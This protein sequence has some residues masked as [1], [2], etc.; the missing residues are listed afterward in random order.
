MMWLN[1]NPK[2]DYVVCYIV[3]M[4]MRHNCVLILSLQ[5]R[6]TIKSDHA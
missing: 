3:T 1:Q 5:V 6:D 4:D 2:S